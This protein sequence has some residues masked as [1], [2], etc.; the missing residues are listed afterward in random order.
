MAEMLVYKGPHWMDALTQ[1]AID[2][3]KERAAAA[4]VDWRDVQVALTSAE[5]TE[6]LRG[7][8]QDWRTAWTTRHNEIVNMTQA[9]I[10]VVCETNRMMF[11]NKYDSRY[12][13]GDIFQVLPDGTLWDRDRNNWRGPCTSSK[14]FMLRIAGL[15][16]DDAKSYAVVGNSRRRKY[17]LK[18]Q[19]LSAGEVSDITTN[20]QA[21]ISLVSFNSKLEDK[22]SVINHG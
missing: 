5:I 2:A 12:Q 18:I 22:G 4:Y 15:S 13:E 10:D 17:R 6:I 3:Y 14:M 9:E 20:K 8:N 19:E 7:R 1:E 11:Q 21:N 16:Y